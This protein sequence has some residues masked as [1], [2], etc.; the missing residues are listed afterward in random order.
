MNE[1]VAPFS[2]SIS[3]LSIQGWWGRGLYYQLVAY[4]QM[5]TKHKGLRN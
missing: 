5:K 2:V 1:C 3:E 4:M